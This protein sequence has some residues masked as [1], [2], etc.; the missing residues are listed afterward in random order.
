LRRHGSNE[1]RV[2]MPIG[3]IGSRSVV[4]GLGVLASLAFTAAPSWAA[5]E[6]A[7]VCH[8]YPGTLFTREGSAF[9][10]T[11]AC[12][13]YA[14]KGGQLVGIDA[15][16]EPPV[17]GSFKETC[18]GFGLRPSTAAL[19]FSLDC[20]AAYN[21][22]FTLDTIGEVAADGTALVSTVM[23]CTFLR[24]NVGSLFAGGIAS[25]FTEVRAEFPRPSGC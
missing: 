20:G 17:E 6:Q 16:A 18:T 7:E 3:R 4:V 21:R 13:E 1:R 12:V 10:N 8:S 25:D 9:K 5:K 19:G 15:V 11:R 14:R 22:D 23:P 24:G 2:L